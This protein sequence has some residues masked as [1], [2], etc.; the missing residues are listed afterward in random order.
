MRYTPELSTERIM[1]QCFFKDAFWNRFTII[2]YFP[3]K[4][5]SLSMFSI[6]WITQEILR[7]TAV[8]STTVMIIFLKKHEDVLRINTA[9][10]LP[11]SKSQRALCISHF[12][13]QSCHNC[14]L[15]QIML[16]VHL[17]QGNMLWPHVV[18]L[19]NSNNVIY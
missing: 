14:P 17:T 18:Q 3:L 11:S 6:Y 9:D 15:E 4:G 19:Q 5:L 13:K 7:L 1:Q 2:C 8:V 16:S 12:W 10:Y